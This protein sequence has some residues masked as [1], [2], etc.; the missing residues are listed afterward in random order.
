MRVDV[1]SICV[2]RGISAVHIFFARLRARRN[3]ACR[4]RVAD[5][6]REASQ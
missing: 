1:F 4:T 3:S 2:L 5:Q 6:K